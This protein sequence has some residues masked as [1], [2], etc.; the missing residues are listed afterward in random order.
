MRSSVSNDI[1]L[2]ANVFLIAFELIS[3][4]LTNKSPI[5]PNIT[6]KGIRVRYGILASN[7]VDVILNECTLKTGR[8]WFYFN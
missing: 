7:P 2:I 4:L 8:F 3:F 5:Y 6:A 1:Q